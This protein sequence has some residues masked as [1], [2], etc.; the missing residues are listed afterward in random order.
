VIPVYNDWESVS[1][2]LPLVDEQLCTIGVQ[3]DILIVDDGSTAAPPRPWNLRLTAIRTVRSLRLKRNV[4][5]QRAICIGLCFLS[6]ACECERVLVMDG[7]GEDA[8]A[9]I[10][11][12]LG[13]LQEDDAV[14]IVFAERLKRS[15]GWVFSFFYALYRLAH[16][17]LVGHRVRVGNYSVMNRECL[18]SLC[19]SPEMWNHYAA[20]VY[21][22]RQPKAFIPTRRARR[23]AGTST[24]NFPALVTHGLSALS[25]FSD[26]ISTRLLIVSIIAGL[27][28]VAVLLLT[29]LLRLATGYA[30][31]GWVA[32][33]GGTVLLFLVQIVAIV[34]TFCFLVLITRG[35]NAFI[36]ARDSRLFV[37]DCTQVWPT[38]GG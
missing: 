32:S 28:T 17:I 6:E 36:P 8:P 14:G 21:A 35:Q 23:L 25:V 7:D 24:M 18:E 10:S 27:V 9:D 22:T 26:R 15:E 20:A 1:L 5:H 16:W 29:G 19:V 38:G 2:L 4:G 34:F 13:R 31:P 33:I 3:A 37:R 11:R 12:L 30:V